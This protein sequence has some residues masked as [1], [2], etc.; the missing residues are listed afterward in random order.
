MNGVDNGC[1]VKQW[2]WAIARERTVGVKS[3]GVRFGC[4]PGKNDSV[5]TASRWGGVV[6]GEAQMC[7]RGAE[8]NGRLTAAPLSWGLVHAA[9]WVIR[10][11]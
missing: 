7:T 8:I 10:A 9:R 4:A 11:A 3:V 6:M 5:R 1:G 2:L